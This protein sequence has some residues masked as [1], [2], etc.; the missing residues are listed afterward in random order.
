MRG[1]VVLG[2]V[3]VDGADGGLRAPDGGTVT[4]REL[5]LPAALLLLWVA[6][7]VRV[8]FY[9]LLEVVATHEAFVAGRAGEAFFS[10]VRAQ[11]A[12]QLVRTE[13]AFAAE[14]PV[15]DEG[16]L[17]GVPAQVRLQVRH[18]WNKRRGFS[19]G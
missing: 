6:R 4:L 17:A 14:E 15:A 7:L 9:V 12:L 19:F 11:M 16:A 3:G 1:A 2:A 10:R 18:L 8:R 13:E 5:A